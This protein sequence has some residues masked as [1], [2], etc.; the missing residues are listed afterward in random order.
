MFL[1]FRCRES[2]SR[3]II[4]HVHFHKSVK[5]VRRWNLFLRIRALHDSKEWELIY[6]IFIHVCFQLLVIQ[7]GHIDL[8]I[9]GLFQY[10][11]RNIFSKNIQENGEKHFQNCIYNTRRVN[12]PRHLCTD[13][14]LHFRKKIN[15]TC[16]RNR[17]A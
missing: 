7:V 2:F 16:T 13:I 5:T 9:Y 3:E 8:S 11:Y 1:C 14:T 12:A 4:W 10:R 17:G 6:N 15:L